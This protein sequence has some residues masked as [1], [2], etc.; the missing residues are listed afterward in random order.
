MMIVNGILFCCCL[1]S[2]LSKSPWQERFINIWKTEKPGE[3]LKSVD[4]ITGFKY[5]LVPSQKVT[6]NDD[7]SLPLGTVYQ[8]RLKRRKDKESGERGEEDSRPYDYDKAYEEFVKKYFDDSL[9]DALSISESWESAD[10]ETPED[11]NVSSEEEAE[12]YE[13][14]QPLW[15]ASTKSSKTQKCKN[16]TRGQKSCMICKNSRNG[17]ASENCSYNKDTTPSGYKLEK[18]KNYH[19]YLNPSPYS[20][21]EEES[22]EHISAVMR[23]APLNTNSTASSTICTTRR[24]KHHTCYQCA[25]PKGEKE[26]KCFAKEMP[27]NSNTNG[28]I[29]QLKQRT[30]SRPNV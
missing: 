28:I 18:Q 12:S 1:N 21:D 26:T 27:G 6:R 15:G 29:G 14:Q 24:S 23:S 11:G 30:K 13:E 16:I 9:T 19:K 17:E 7:S 10:Y 22:A 4:A 2:V 8:T 3:L 25:N 20:S 5:Q